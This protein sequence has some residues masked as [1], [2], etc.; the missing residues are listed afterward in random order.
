ML[1]K[2]EHCDV[3]KSCALEAENGDFL[4]DTVRLTCS[5]SLEHAL[6]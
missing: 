6:T 5:T 2:Q 1:V 3:S 4:L